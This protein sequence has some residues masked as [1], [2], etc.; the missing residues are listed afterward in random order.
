[1]CVSFNLYQP[2]SSNLKLLCVCARFFF[3]SDQDT[4]RP[5]IQNAELCCGK[6]AGVVSGKYRHRWAGKIP[7]AIPPA[8]PPE[9]AL[10]T[11]QV[12]CDQVFLEGLCASL[13]WTAKQQQSESKKT[14]PFT[15]CRFIIIVLKE[16]RGI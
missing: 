8:N 5:R 15:V 11:K 13:S 14:K 9:P 16:I 3:Q 1:M 12:D 4:T 10:T 6:N 7:P 2:K